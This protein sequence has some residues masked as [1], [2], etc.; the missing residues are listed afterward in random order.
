MALSTISPNASAQFGKLINLAAVTNLIPYVMAMTGLLVIM[1]KA[2]VGPVTYTR[3]ALILVVALCYSFY[4]LYACGMEAVF[5][6][7]LVLA[8]G[9]L[10]YGVIAKRFAAEKR[11]GPAGDGSSSPETTA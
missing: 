8:V 5:G 7:T 10:F 6:G 9:Y 11:A 2:G 1:Y 3:N 4:A